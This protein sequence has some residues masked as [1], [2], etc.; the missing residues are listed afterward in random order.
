MHHE[1][2]DIVTM[3]SRVASSILDFGNTPVSVVRARLTRGYRRPEVVQDVAV[4][5]QALCR[6]S[7]Q[8]KEPRI[9]I[10][11]LC[12]DTARRAATRGGR[13]IELTPREWRAPSPRRWA[14]S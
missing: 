14:C 5:V 4:C 7:Y 2:A 8:R 6:R 3:V 12:I 1:L 13:P 10:D 11:D 9:E